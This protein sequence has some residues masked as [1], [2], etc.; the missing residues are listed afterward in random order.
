M[1]VGRETSAVGRNLEKIQT[2][3]GRHLLMTSRGERENTRRST[4]FTSEKHSFLDLDFFNVK[5]VQ[6]QPWK[7]AVEWRRT[8]GSVRAA[9]FAI[10]FQKTL[11]GQSAGDVRSLSP[12][13]GGGA[14]GL[15]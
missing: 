7:A 8:D 6:L 3:K 13:A 5:C 4:V 10:L 2:P 11:Q 1:P 15:R 14:S 9:R 12:H